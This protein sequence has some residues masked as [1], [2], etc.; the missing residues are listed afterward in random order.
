MMSMKNIIAFGLLSRLALMVYGGWQDN[1]FKVKFTDVDYHVFTDAANYTL[2]GF[3]PYERATY[4]YTPIIAWLLMPCHILHIA[5]GKVLF[6]LA[7]LIVAKMIVQIL[8]MY[9]IDENAIKIAV[10]TWLFNPIII[11]VSCRGNAESIISMSVIATVYCLLKKNIILS[12]LLFGFSIHLKI[13]PVVSAL[14]FFLYLRN[15]DVSLTKQDSLLSKLIKLCKSIFQRNILLFFLSAAAFLVLT[16]MLCYALYGVEF[17]NHAYLYHVTRKDIRHNFSIYFYMLYTNLQWWLGLVG[18]VTQLIVVVCL[19]IN[20]YKDIIFC[21]FMITYAF[22]TFNKI[23]TSQY[24]L[25]YLTFI[26]FLVPGMYHVRLREIAAA[27]FVWLGAQSLWL[28]AA[29]KLE[30]EGENFFTFVWCSSVMFF[31]VNIFIMMWFLK[32]YKPV[33][34]LMDDKCCNKKND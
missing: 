24:F 27:V 22:V 32:R 26:P 18:F 34:R 3:S 8:K 19:S 29:Y 1:N 23:C 15:T 7:D 30:F 28:S 20:L 33:F 12:G 21:N 25:W 6:V 4:R 9:A 5:W 16:T 31:W 13:F 14:A 2:N 17:L 11:T 10:S